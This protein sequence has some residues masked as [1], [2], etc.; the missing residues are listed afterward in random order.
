MVRVSVDVGGEDNRALIG[1]RLARSHGDERRQVVQVVAVPLP[2]RQREILTVHVVDVATRQHVGV[3]HSAG[4]Q[5]SQVEPGHRVPQRVRRDGAERT[6]D[7][8]RSALRAPGAA[9][10]GTADGG[11]QRRFEPAGETGVRTGR[12]EDGL[13]ALLG[14]AEG[15]TGGPGGRVLVDD[16]HA[17]TLDKVLQRELLGR[18]VGLRA[19]VRA[20]DGA[21]EEHVDTGER[22]IG[23]DVDRR[24]DLELRIHRAVRPEERRVRDDA[25]KLAVVIAVEAPRAGPCTCTG[26]I[27]TRDD[28]DA[29]CRRGCRGS[30][31]GGGHG[32]HDRR[33][34]RRHEQRRREE[35]GDRPGG[36]A[37][38]SSA[39]ELVRV[40]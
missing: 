5:R 21:G 4:G 15:L 35:C 37:E 19:A 27:V 31:V 20:L 9:R 39:R 10:R 7:E 11:D 8:R 13:G 36:P 2:Q 22:R 12:L 23:D 38:S 1:D 24:A 14:D 16:D 26:G 6:L 25:A 3:D 29:W 17:A 34:R 28:I 33:N 40:S 30:G 18:V 32:G